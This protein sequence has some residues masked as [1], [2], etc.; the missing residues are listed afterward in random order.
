MTREAGCQLFAGQNKFH[1]TWMILVI[2]LPTSF[3]KLQP[4]LVVICDRESHD[5]QAEC[6]SERRR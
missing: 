5:Q 2:A 4:K 1:S 3:L 6:Q